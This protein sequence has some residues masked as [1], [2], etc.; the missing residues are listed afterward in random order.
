MHDVNL[1]DALSIVD[2]GDLPVSPG[3]T[4]R[5]YAQVEEGL[6]KAFAR[7]LAAIRRANLLRGDVG[8][9]AIHAKRDTLDHVTLALF[10]PIGFML[11]QPL[12]TATDVAA[13]LPAPFA[14]EDKYDGIRAQAHVGAEH[15]VLFSRT[16]DTITH[17]YPEVVGAL[18]GLPPGLVLDGELIAY[19]PRAPERALPFKALQQRLG[20]KRPSAT[21]LE[22]VPV[23]FVAYDVLAADCALVIDEPYRARRARLEAMPW[24]GNGARLAPAHL[25]SGADDVEAAF[26]AAR[27]AGNEGIIAKDP[28]AP[29]APGRRGGAWIK[30]KTSSWLPSSADTGGGGAC[31]PTT[32]SPSARRRTTRPC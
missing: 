28:G 19:D 5:T 13:A 12:P 31:S 6:A 26:V 9:V 23:A 8:E 3:D 24:P 7:P 15:V 22:E 14:V 10:H 25:V 11:A 17:G 16:L 1:V 21:L 32:R 18:A 20:R 27:A 30:L 2:Y 29:Y 4:E